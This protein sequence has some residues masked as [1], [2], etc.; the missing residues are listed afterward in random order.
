MSKARIFDSNLIDPEAIVTQTASS[1]NSFYPDTNLYN[2]ARRAKS[3]RTAG[4]W[5]IPAADNTVDI[6]ENGAFSHLVTFTPGTYTTTAAFIAQIQADFNAAATANI[7]VS[8]DTSGRFVITSDGAGF[9]IDWTYGQV[10]ATLLGFDPLVDDTGLLTYTADYPRI[11]QEEWVKWDF[12]TSVSPTS[13]I[14]IGTRQS[15]IQLTPSAVVTLQ[16]NSSDSWTSPA[17][18]Q[19]LTGDENGYYKIQATA[20]HGTPMRY[21]RLKIVDQTNP[22]GYIEFAKVYLGSY[23]EPTRAAVQFP[24]GTS[25]EDDSSSVKTYG[26][27]LFTDIKSKAIGFAP[28]WFGLTV[29]EKERF[30]DHFESAGVGN[31]WF[32]QLDPDLVYSTTVGRYL[33]YVRFKEAPSFSLIAPGVFGCNMNLT[34]EL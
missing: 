28:E 33:R 1:A 15:G 18:S 5:V 16:A 30:E 20:L 27:Q 24:F 8:Q 4:Y 6:L 25:Y 11:H 31:P 13:C 34:E 7:T 2:Y 3:W 10:M 26:G 12:G 14:I 19:V 17:Y 22:N 32:I 29:A 9:E 21:W 23:Y